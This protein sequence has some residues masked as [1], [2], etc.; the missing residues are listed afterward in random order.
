M[1]AL[2]V[3]LLFLMT[4]LP[5]LAKKSWEK[6][7]KDWTLDDCDHVLTMSPW[8]SESYKPISGDDH[9]LVQ[10]Q[11]VSGV[12]VCAEAREE[13][14]DSGED[15]KFLQERYAERLEQEGLVKEKVIK[16]KVFPMKGVGMVGQ[17]LHE[18]Y[19]SD[20]FFAGLPD[21]IKLIRN[22]N[23]DDFIKPKEFG[24]LGSSLSEGFQVVFPNN[25]FISARTWRA[26]L[27]L[28]TDAG[29]FKF[30]FEPKK[31]KPFDFK[32]KM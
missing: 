32:L 3:V 9:Y 29:E 31:M 18:L 23:R 7:P 26:E 16:I 25:G 6:N 10:A 15:M 17:N 24:P 22:K 1:K 11:W 5:A 21:K 2:Y 20:P 27:L 13:Q 30:I 19:S 4:A 28:D 14:L 12:V 8:R